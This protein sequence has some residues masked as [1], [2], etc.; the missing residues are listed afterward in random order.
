MNQLNS[1][2]SFKNFLLLWSGQSL[3]QLGSSMTSFALIIWAYKQQGTVTSIALLSVFSYLPCI[4][5]SLFAGAFT[6]RFSKKR[7]MLVCDTLAALCTLFAFGAISLGIL[8]IWHLYIINA[9]TGAMNA[10]QSPASKVVTTLMVPKDQYVKVSGLR[11][12]S[13]SINTVFSPILATTVMAFFGIHAVL[14]I[15]LSTFLIAFLSLL[16]VVKIPKDTIAENNPERQ[17]MM[18]DIVEGFAYLKANRG[19]LHIMLFMSVINFL[20]SMAFF[21]VLPAMILSRS[22]GNGQVVGLVNAAIGVGGIVGSLIVS[23]AKP[24]R[25]KVRMIYSSAGLSFLLCDLFLGLG[26]E[27]WIWIVASFAGNMP[28]PFLNA[29]ENALLQLKIPQS[30]MGRVFS[31]RGAIQFV[32]IPLGYLAGGFLSDTVFEP[33]MGKASHI[34]SFLALFVGSGKGSGM[35]LIFIFTGIAGSLFSL[36]AYQ[37]KHVRELERVS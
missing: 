13:D 18:T 33:L 2:K 5:V 36:I 28:I 37:N 32:T 4:F 17:N 10:F 7:I 12:L 20:A 16:L 25:N 24:S 6:D 1:Q 26:R 30:I 27:P 11:S 14:V 22:H 31:I 23:L 29:A 3:S 34:Q 35:A 15:D 9:L 19:F 21:S 8:K